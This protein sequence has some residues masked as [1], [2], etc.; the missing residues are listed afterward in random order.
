MQ[1]FWCLPSVYVQL[2]FVSLAGLLPWH[3][4]KWWRQWTF[5]EISKSATSSGICWSKCATESV[6]SWKWRHNLRPPVSPLPRVSWELRWDKTWLKHHALWCSPNH[7]C[8]HIGPFP[9]PSW[10]FFGQEDFTSIQPT[11]LLRTLAGRS[12]ASLQF[13]WSL[14][15]P[16]DNT[17]PP[18][19]LSVSLSVCQSVSLSVCLSV[20]LSI[21]PPIYLSI[22]RSMDLSIYPSIHL[23]TYLFV[24]QN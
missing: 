14:T 1:R 11:G 12:T 23:S 10:F 6:V 4:A 9:F 19:H 8:N 22:Y 13:W 7:T 24:R 2:N 17:C 5:R 3:K 18:I 15:Y 20:C 16:T 21:Y